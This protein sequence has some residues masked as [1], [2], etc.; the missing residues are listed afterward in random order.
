MGKQP[1]HASRLHCR[2]LLAT[3]LGLLIGA[4]MGFGCLQF[5]DAAEAQ[6]T[7]VIVSSC[8]AFGGGVGLLVTGALVLVSGPSVIIR[9][10]RAVHPLVVNVL[11][12]LTV[13]VLGGAILGS[14]VLAVSTTALSMTGQSPMD[15]LAFAVAMGAWG[16]LLGGMIGVFIGAVGG[17]AAGI[18]EILNEKASPH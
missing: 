17:L 7:L 16:A 12:A 11:A 2:H 13:G 9:R 3:P 15:R 4:A 6:A 5:S 14:V 18:M 1:C 10:G 8:A